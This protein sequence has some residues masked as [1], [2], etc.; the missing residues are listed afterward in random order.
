MKKTVIKYKRMQSTLLQRQ[1]L[2]A[3][4]HTLTSRR[5]PK[6]RETEGE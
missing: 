1:K 2:F 3:E 5:K 6:R 4:I